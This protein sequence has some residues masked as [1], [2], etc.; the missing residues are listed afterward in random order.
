[1]TGNRVSPGLPG[2]AGAAG[3]SAFV[4]TATN[5][6]TA[7]NNVADQ[8]MDHG[9]ATTGLVANGKLACCG[10]DT[11]HQQFNSAGNPRRCDSRFEWDG[12]FDLDAFH[13]RA[14]ILCDRVH[15]T[16]RI[17]GRPRHQINQSVL[18]GA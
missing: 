15:P 11:D 16:C 12:L 8:Q 7:V 13:W 1:M 9:Q 10:S 18:R 3:A 6:N 17:R 2:A 4:F 14:C 5:A